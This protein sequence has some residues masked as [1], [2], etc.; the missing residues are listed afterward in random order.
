MSEIEIG[1]N[2]APFIRRLQKSVSNVAQ[3]RGY[4]ITGGG[5]RLHF[6]MKPDG[7][8]DYTHK[9][10]NRVI[11]GTSADQMK[12]ALVAI[13]RAGHHLRLQVHDEAANSVGSHR[14]AEE[15]S[16][17]MSNVM[18]A[19]VPFRVDCEVGASWGTAA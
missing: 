6:P 12:K 18:P 13:D 17:I 8:Y 7:S 11:Q 4:I 5:R 9:S 15:I 19:E 10:L 2:G 3:Q 16:D 1:E 14:E